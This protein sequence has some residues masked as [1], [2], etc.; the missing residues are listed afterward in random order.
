M[1]RITVLTLETLAPGV[2]NPRLRE[3]AC[4]RVELIQDSGVGNVFVVICQNVLRPGKAGQTVQHEQR[5]ELES[6]RGFFHRTYSPRVSI[7]CLRIGTRS[8]RLQSR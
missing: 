3:N 8:C 7:S 1:T 6:Y 5:N 2:K 4:G